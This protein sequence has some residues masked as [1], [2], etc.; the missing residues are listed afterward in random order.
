MWEFESG[1]RAI[2]V[3][4]LAFGKDAD[5]K[6]KLPNKRLYRSI[7]APGSDIGDGNKLFEQWTPEFREASIISGLDSILKRIEYNCGLAR[8]SISDPTVEAKTATEITATKQRTYATI[9]DTQKSIEDTIIQ[10][11]W[12]MDIYATLYKLAP[13]G[14]YS[15]AF[16]FD[17]SVV[18]DKDAQFQQDL[19]L[20]GQS[21]MGPVEFRMRNFGED[22]ATAKQKIAEA[23]EGLQTEASLFNQGA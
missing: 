22:E 21:I 11:I 10:L 20:V 15:T 18:V 19:R 6:S 7:D 9:V 1:K 14:T 12:A 8:G 13:R 5:G 23:R 4:S 2:Y 17:D 3:D 16:D